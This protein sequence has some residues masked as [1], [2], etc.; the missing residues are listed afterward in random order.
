MPLNLLS[1][2]YKIRFQAEKTTSD[3][4]YQTRRTIKDLMEKAD[5]DPLTGL[6]N[7]GYFEKRMPRE[8]S[9][10]HQKKRPLVYAIIDADDFGRLNK[11]HSLPTGDAALRIIADVLRQETRI[12]DWVARYGGEEFAIIMP[13]TML[14]DGVAVVNRLKEAIASK[15]VKGKGGATVPLTVCAG[16]VELSGQDQSVDDLTNRASPVL[17]FAK[18]QPGKNALA[19]QDIQSSQAILIADKPEVNNE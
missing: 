18:D 1:M 11:D 14:E 3:I 16:V 13:D 5:T 4:A 17:K 6:H 8:I 9:D 12:N 10:S 19:Y 7:R 2:E 15:S